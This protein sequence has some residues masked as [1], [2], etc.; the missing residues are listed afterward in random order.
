MVLMKSKPCFESLFY[1]SL[2]R[3]TDDRL[4]GQDGFARWVC[5]MDLQD[6]FDRV[7]NRF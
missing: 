3:L 1:C 2:H 4:G 6:E 7:L 5:K